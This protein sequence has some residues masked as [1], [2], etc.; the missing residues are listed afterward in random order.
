LA[1]HFEHGREGAVMSIEN[2]FEGYDLYRL[3]KNSMLKAREGRY[4]LSD[5][6]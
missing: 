6:T 3:R 5:R 1:R 4:G 2:F